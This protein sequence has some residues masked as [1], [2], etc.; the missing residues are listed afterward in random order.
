MGGLK[1]YNSFSKS[2]RIIFEIFERLVDHTFKCIRR[3]KCY[4][5]IKENIG[6]DSWWGKSG[7]DKSA[8]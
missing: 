5:N 7:C 8:K 2:I 6:G 3:L 1:H 4:H